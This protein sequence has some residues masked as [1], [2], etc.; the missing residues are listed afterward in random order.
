M[1]SLRDSHLVTLCYCYLQINGRRCPLEVCL[2]RK[3]GHI[4][5]V[6]RIIDWYEHQKSFVIVMERPEAVQDL[7]DFITEQGPLGEN[8]SRNFFTQV[9]ETI[10][11]CHQAGVLHGDMKDENLL[12]EKKSGKLRL[13]DFGS[14]SWLKE[15][16]YTVFDG[17]CCVKYAPP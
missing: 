13:I 9:V 10:L 4:P 8:L 12:V 16:T 6:I 17:K 11:K 5:G 2:L 7:F 14:G 1:Q 15:S 3:L